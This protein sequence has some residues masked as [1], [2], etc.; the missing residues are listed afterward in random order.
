M[1]ESRTSCLRHITLG[2]ILLY[3]IAVLGWYITYLIVGDGFWILAV[4]NAFA[5]HLF[6]PLP[7][8]ALLGVLARHRATW[9]VTLVVALLFLG[10]FG[11]DLMPPILVDR[12][13][14]SGP[15]LTV[16]TYNVLF[17]TTDATPIA[18]SVTGADADIVAFQELT[19]PLVQR[20]EQEIG[21]LYPHRTPVHN[22][23]RYDVAIWSRYPLQAESAYEDMPCHV[24]SVVVDLDGQAVRVVD[25][26]AQPF[27][28]I[29]RESIER[30]FHLRERQISRILDTTRDQPEP[31]I[32]LGDLNTAPT[33][34]VYDTL[35]AHLSDAFR[36]AGWGLGHTY[37][38]TGEHF[39][40]TRYPSRLARLDHIFTSEQWQ[41]TAAWVGDWD[42]SSDHLPVIAQLKLDPDH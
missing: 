21:A 23:C 39:W 34:Q 4:V 8:A 5:V 40:G 28:G 32:I 10:L 33:Q 37:P 20:L 11:G 36:V 24:R 16:M 41:A 19:P 1:K 2:A 35:S 7:L 15:S 25:V 26:H 29:D 22:E 6:A 3:G 30:S 42:G 17:H 14:I 18:T 12:K 27:S 13:G 31:L 9:I 38:A